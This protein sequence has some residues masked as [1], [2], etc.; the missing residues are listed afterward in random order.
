MRAIHAEWTA[1]QQRVKTIKCRALVETFYP[2]GYLSA[3]S[4]LPPESRQ[5]KPPQPEEDKRFVNEPYA[6]AIDFAA[7]RIRKEYELTREMGYQDRDPEFFIDRSLCLYA[8]N[9]YQHFQPMSCLPESA[10]GE[11]AQDVTI[12]EGG[13]NDWML[14]GADLPLLWLAGGVN[15]QFPG[16]ARPQFLDDIGRFSRHGDGQWDGHDCVI[17][18]VPE[19]KDNKAV[20]EFWVGR[21]PPYPIYHCRA[22]SGDR[23]YWQLEVTYREQGAELLP[24]QWTYTGYTYHPGQTYCRQTFSVQELDLN[25]PLAAELFEKKLE[26]GMVAFFPQKNNQKVKVGKAG[27]LAALGSSSGKTL[28]TVLAAAGAVLALSLISVL[29]WRWLGRRRR[30]AS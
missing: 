15:G 1:R 20:R 30:L 13:A 3:K 27:E 18:T 10:R 8:D 9:K 5:G 7:Q 4:D 14:W 23:V 16:P 28:L 22:R 29:L 11:G 6:L 24:A 25:S 19:Q 2:R 17:L 21:T 26:P 12:Y